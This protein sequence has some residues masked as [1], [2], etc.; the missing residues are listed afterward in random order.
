MSRF[1][2][3]LL[4]NLVWLNIL[5]V[6]TTSVTL[7]L[8]GKEGNWFFAYCNTTGIQLLDYVVKFGLVTIMILTVYFTL[9]Y[10][11]RPST[12]KKHPTQSKVAVI[13]V[14]LILLGLNIFYLYVVVN[15]INVLNYQIQEVRKF[16]P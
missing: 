7:R 1:F 15:N 10:T 14:F 4:L 6:I 5:D 16:I 3:L 11:K 8:H 13:V 9:W 12:V 2:S